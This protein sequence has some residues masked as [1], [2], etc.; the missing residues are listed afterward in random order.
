MPG[1]TLRGRLLNVQSHVVSGHVGGQAGAL[2]L[3]LLGWD[4]SL[5]PTVTFSNHPAYGSFKGTRTDPSLLESLLDGLDANGLARFDRLLTGYIPSPEACHVVALYVERLR[6]AN[7]ELVYVLDPVLGESGNGFY[8]DQNLAPLYRQLA[9]VATIVTPNHFEAEVLSGV[10]I[11]DAASLREALSVLHTG[12]GAPH[13]LITSVELPAKIIQSTAP[14]AEGAVQTLVG[15]SYANSAFK[16]W[17]L[18]TPSV[19]GHYSGTGD[20]LA[21]L[22]AGRFTSS[23]EADKQLQEAAAYAATALHQVLVNTSTY[24][25]AQ[26]VHRPPADE[27][28]VASVM[29]N[30]PVTL[31]H[32]SLDAARRELR[33]IESQDAFDTRQTHRFPIEF[34]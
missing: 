6:A 25:Q 12:L 20:L 23:P 18:R 8:V 11:I 17:A 26:E 9:G 14:E 31:T 2:P 28:V 30:D 34:I 24:V 13:V 15:S 19:P 7:P 27:T 1:S 5:V 10:K 33:I 21:A 22:I 4:V 16:P 32:R 29:G 3:A